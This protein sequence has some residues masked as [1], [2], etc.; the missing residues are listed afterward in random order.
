LC[1]KSEEVA[2]IERSLVLG[3]G[4]FDLFTVAWKWWLLENNLL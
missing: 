1:S 4:H 3:L 2:V